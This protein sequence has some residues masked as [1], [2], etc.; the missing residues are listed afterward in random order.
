MRLRISGLAVAALTVALAGCSSSTRAADHGTT[1]LSAP[2]PATGSVVAQAKAHLGTN[3]AG[4]DRPLPASAPTPPKGLNVWVIACSMSAEGCSDPAKGFADAAKALGWS[5]HLVDGKLDP[6]TYNGAVRDAIAAKANAIVL[7]SVDCALTKAS[8]QAA[9]SAGILVG[10]LY[11]LDCDDTYAGGHSKLFDFE[12]KY[13]HGQSYGQYMTNTYAPSI[14]DYVI[15]KTDGH[16]NVIAMRENDVAIV[17]HIGDAFVARM[18]QC[19]SCKLTSVEFTG[20]DFTSGKLQ[21]KVQTELTR[22]PAANV[23]FAPYDASVT[24][25][26]AAGVKAAGRDRSVLL[27][28]G[29]GLTPNIQMIRSGSG[30]DFAAGAPARWAGWAT[31]DELIRA[32]DKQ[33]LVDEGIGI[34]SIDATHNLPTKTPNYDGNKDSGYE[35]HYRKIW[36]L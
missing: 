26:I 29:E 34:Q 3:Y 11:G 18:Q 23:V 36:G 20:A 25:G 21:A 12:I 6:G 9:K 10:G 1:S 22:N 13:D 24:L 32:A 33:P 4:T 2:T 14:A 30:Q 8:L 16:A 28:G 35:A 15:A 19:S 31:A 27:T 5:T 7:V 17:R